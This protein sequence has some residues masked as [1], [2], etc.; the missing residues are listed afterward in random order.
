MAMGFVVKKFR[1]AGKARERQVENNAR[2]RP[3]PPTISLGNNA[4][5]STMKGQNM[6]QQSKLAAAKPAPKSPPAQTVRSE[7]QQTGVDKKFTNIRTDTS[8][9]AFIIPPSKP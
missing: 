7:P 2:Q 3:A 1:G 9:P 4:R 6:K 8:A 5:G